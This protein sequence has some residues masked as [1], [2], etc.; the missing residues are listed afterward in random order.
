MKKYSLLLLFFALI[1][2]YISCKKDQPQ[3]GV[4]IISFNPVKGAPGNLITI[5]GKGFGSSTSA[6]KLLVVAPL[7]HK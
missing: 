1:L 5:T 7:D 2:L 4:T 3:A 6:L